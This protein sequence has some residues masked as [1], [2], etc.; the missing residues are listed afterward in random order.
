[1]AAMFQVYGV[2]LWAALVALVLIL[3][4][5]VISL[6]RRVNGLIEHY[7][8]ITAGVADGTLRDALER[9]IGRLD[10]ATGQVDMLTEVCRSVEDDL[11]RTIQR[12]GIVRFNPFADTG[13]DQSFA[14]A[15]L[16]AA[17]SGVVLSSLF[18]RSSTRVFAKAI[19]DGRSPHV[20]TDE[21]RDAIAQAMSANALA[22]SRS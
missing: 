21:E 16:D 11:R 3:A 15:L 8:R 9:Y 6:Q 19:V 2:F 10:E 12:V 20:L 22:L 14:V 13:G 5:W 18:S 17:G 7:D 4:V 1:M